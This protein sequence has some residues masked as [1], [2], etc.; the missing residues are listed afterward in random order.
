MPLKSKVKTILASSAITSPRSGLRS[1]VSKESERTLLDMDNVL[2]KL[3]VET[4]LDSIS[5]CVH[6]GEFVGIIG[7]NGA[8][9]TTLLR[10]MLGLQPVT[11]GSI[12]R[13][14]AGGISYIPQRNNMYGSPVPL[15]VIEVVGLGTRGKASG[16]QEALRKV[17]M[18]DAAHKPFTELSGG[19]QQRVLIA[20]ALAA[21]PDILLLDEP[22]TGI[23]ERSQ[24]TFYDILRT[25]QQHN[26]TIVMVSHD[27][28]TV[29]SLVTR[30][31][32]LNQTILYDGAPE[33][34]EADK[35]LPKLY[36]TQHRLL[37]H[38]HHGGVHA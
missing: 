36:K 9:K 24:A 12:D 11:S 8:G 13:N 18:Q 16:V 15:S 30:V 20:K 25:L 27:V 4:I 31:V 34:F 38:H 22:T 32:C 23:D 35:Y 33:H 26:I 10:T 5:L 2:V 14:L 29:L 17:G 3:G 1:T 19:Q 21:A 28:D 37:H 6:A 7:P